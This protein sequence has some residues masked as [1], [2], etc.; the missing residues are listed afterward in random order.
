MLINAIL[1]IHLECMFQSLTVLLELPRLTDLAF[2]TQHFVSCNSLKH[3]NP[4]TSGP[5]PTH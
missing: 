2:H 5:H 3:M 1:T 4:M